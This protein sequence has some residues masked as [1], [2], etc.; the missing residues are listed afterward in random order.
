MASSNTLNSYGWRDQYYYCSSWPRSTNLLLSWQP[1]ADQHLGIREERKNNSFDRPGCRSFDGGNNVP[2]AVPWS[3][4]PQLSSTGYLLAA[5]ASSLHD[6]NALAGLIA[7]PAIIACIHP[8]KM[9]W[10]ARKT[11]PFSSQLNLCDAEACS[12][13]LF[14]PLPPVIHRLSLKSVP[15]HAI[16]ARGMAVTNL[17][18]DLLD[19]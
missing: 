18:G 10:I 3:Q 14:T 15:E 13:F 19:R 4:S 2:A 6:S 12:R 1:D 11:Q 16:K 17:G 8:T 9:G 7:F 5:V